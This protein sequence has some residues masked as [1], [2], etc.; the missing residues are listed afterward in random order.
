MTPTT[1]T[2]EPADDLYL[3][4]LTDIFEGPLDLLVHLIKKNE[5]DI[6]DIPI[7]VITHSYLSY[8]DLMRQMNIDI[9]GDFVVM[10]A[11]L[12]HIKSRMLLPLHAIDGEEEEDPRLELVRP[13]EEYLAMKSAAELLSD[14]NVLG[15]ETFVRTVEMRKSVTPDENDLVQ[16]G[17]FELV[18]AFKGILANLAGEHKVDISSE[19]ISVRD[20]M[21]EL[22]DILELKGSVTFEELFTESS[23]RHEVIVTFLAI[24]EMA[25]MTLIT[26]AQHISSGIIRIIYQ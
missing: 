24:L 9:A 3:V 18:D 19:R 16:I 5:V 8:L 17:L 26:I 7:A 13:L 20:R 23:D 12:T 22:I 1:L 6:Y 4:Q 11:T 2:P 15:Q 21:N 14:R 10:A 25:K